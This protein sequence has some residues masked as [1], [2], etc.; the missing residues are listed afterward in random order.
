MCTAV[1]I[2]PI[3]PPFGLIYEGAIGQPRQTTSLYDPLQIIFASNNQ[4]KFLY[5]QQRMKGVRE[6]KADSVMSVFFDD[7][8]ICLSRT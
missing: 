8:L 7:Q 4:F 3:P 2:V 1:L 5:L 6:G